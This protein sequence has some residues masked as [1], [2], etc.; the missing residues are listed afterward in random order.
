MRQFLGYSKILLWQSFGLAAARNKA[1]FALRLLLPLVASGMFVA[2]LYKTAVPVILIA[3]GLSLSVCAGI[4]CAA[5]NGRPSVLYTLPLSRAR[6]TAYLVA[7]IL[8]ASL[9]LSVV[10]WAL[11]III[12]FFVLCPYIAETGDFMALFSPPQKAAPENC[13]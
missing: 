2:I 4:F 11:F 3:F 1:D 6:R 13:P 5:E 12:K 8:M 10:I 7:C 9:A